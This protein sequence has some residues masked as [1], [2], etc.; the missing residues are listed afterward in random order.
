[1]ISGEGFQDRFYFVDGAEYRY[2]DGAAVAAVTMAAPGTAPTLAGSGSG[3]FNGTYKGKVV[4]VDA[5]GV[6]SQASPASAGA[7]TAADGQIDWTNIPVGPAGTVSRRLYRT[8]ANG[9]TYYRLADI[10][11]NV[12]TTYTDTMSDATLETQDELAVDLDLTPVRRCTQ[13]LWHNKSLRFFFG[14][15]GSPAMYYTE[16][17]QPAQRKAVSTC[18]PTSG[19]GKLLGLVELDDCVIAEYE[20]GAR[21][22]AGIDPEI[23]ASWGRVPTKHSTKAPR[24]NELMSDGLAFAGNGGLFLMSPSILGTPG[25]ENEERL[26]NLAGDRLSTFFEEIADPAGA[27]ATFDTGK[28]RLYIAADN[29]VIVAEEALAAFSR[30]TGIA[31]HDILFK[32]NKET[33]IAID[34]Y[35]LKLDPASW[36]DVLSDGSFAPIAL[37]VKTDKLDMDAPDKKKYFDHLQVCF[38]N[39]HFGMYLLR[40]R[41]Y[42]DGTLVVDEEYEPQGTKDEITASFDIKRDGVRIEVELSNDQMDTPTTVDWFGIEYEVIEESFGREL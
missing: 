10:G 14:G 30:W 23:D 28:K 4:F 22:W 37:D 3:S 15:D 41:V 19:Q 13:M 17:N 5:F 32:T 12:A 31:A 11:N 29:Q 24:T 33:W 27:T 8:L 34:N 9:D 7:V 1:L 38:V 21:Y 35:I 2:Y 26:V 39:P 16:P 42:V 6:E 18:V 40:V 20:I 36:H 25:A